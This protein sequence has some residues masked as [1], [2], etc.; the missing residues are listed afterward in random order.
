MDE[1]LKKIVF[2]S[3]KAEKFFTKLMAYTLGPAELKAKLEDGCNVKIIDVRENSD[4]V[5][6]HIPGAISIPRAQLDNK[7][8]DL[9]K[10]DVHIVY[11]Y[12]HQ[13][14]LATCACRLLASKGY[15]C[16]HLDGGFKVWSEDFHYAT[17]KE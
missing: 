1:K 12:N 2:D 14:H 13:C 7:L 16:M 4:Y 10:E 11:C 15:P 17:S 6:G 3:D 5:E 9:S 8:E